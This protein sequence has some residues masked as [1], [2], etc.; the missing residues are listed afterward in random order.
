MNGNWKLSSFSQRDENNP[1]KEIRDLS[2]FYIV[3]G[4]EVTLFNFQSSDFTYT[5]VPGTGRNY[6]GTSGT[7]RFDN[8]DAP[9]YLY[10]ENESDTLEIKLGSMPHTFDNQLSLEL[11]R[12]CYD[13][14]GIPTP[15]VSYIF[16]IQRA[17]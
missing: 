1:I 9:A 3:A 8:N 13:S 14:N 11:P 4:E 17:N 7:W 16:T 6:F 2:D 10:L 15:T 5:V 12:Y